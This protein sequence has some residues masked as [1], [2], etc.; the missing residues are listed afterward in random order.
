MVKMSAELIKD[1]KLSESFLEQYRNKQPKWGFGGLGYIVYLRTYAR[2]KADGTLERW[3]ETVQRITEGNFKIEARR[4]AEIG[5][6]TEMKVADLMT[7]MERFYHLVFNLV[8]TPPG[9]GLWMSGTEYAEKVGDAENNCWGVSMRPQPYLAGEEPKVSFAPVF[10]F[11]QA[12][13]GGGVGVNIQRKYVNQIPK[14]ENALELTFVCD[15]VHADYHSELKELKVWERFDA[16]EDFTVT[17]SREGWAEALGK[18]IDAHYEGLTELVIDISDIRPRGTDIKGFGGVASGPAPL[19]TMLT[20]VN[21]ILNRRVNDYV[22][23][24]EW[25]DVV[26]L[27]G[28]CVVA[29]NVRRTAL[30]LIGD[31]NDKE[32][33]ESKNYS[34]P[35]NLEASQWRW[36]SNNS[37]DISVNTDR[38]TLRNLAVNIY[39]NGEPGYVNVELSR[40]FGRIIDGFQKDIDGEVEIFNPCGEITLPNTSPCNLFEINLPRVHELIEKGIEGDHLYEEVAYLAARYAYRITF[41]PYEWEATRDVVYRHRRLGVGITG[42]TD[43]VLMRFG[44]KAVVGFDDEGNAQY[45]EEVTAELDRLYNYVKESNIAQAVE[46]QANP[47]IK[48]TTVKPSGTVSLLMG[49]SPGQHYHW[50]P[51][52]VRRIRMAANAPLVPILQECGYYI[53]PAVSG[54]NADGSKKYDYNTL[55]VEFP[56]KAPTA[57]HPKFQSAGDVPLREQAALQALLATYWSDNAVSATLSFKKAQPKPVYFADGSILHDKF[58]QPEL[59][60]D[61]RDEDA[62]IDEITDILDRYKGV[63]K[64][65]SLL[66]HATDTYPQMPYEEI[67]KETYE[68]MVSK[69]TAKPWELINGTVEAEDEDTTDYSSECTG[70]SCPLK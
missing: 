66:P 2:K 55:V 62:I 64:S 35:Q 69:L 3:D 13:K 26:Q 45:N 42:I 5:K 34:L 47:S 59:K 61:K 52:M 18:V 58:G 15:G 4:L 67:T 38:E 39:Y 1:V 28:T 10:T 25:G 32:Y 23:P 30:I 27:I 14:V 40:N 65:T 48:V 46:L 31:Q 17:D 70:N 33:V 36:A 43:W 6:L 29:G 49:V 53:E 8:M 57:E 41:R 24:T 21:E 51:Y 60:I 20:K 19:V 54:F 56:V 12:M 22:T 63:I 9:R 7:E 16:I 11:D 68:E 50:A 37:V 44:E